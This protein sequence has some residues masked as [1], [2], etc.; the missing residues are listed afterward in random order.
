[1]KSTLQDVLTLEPLGAD[2]F[3]AIHHKENFQSSLFGGQVLAQS[4]MAA[5]LT[6]DGSRPHSM[7]AYF[8]RAG[9]SQAPVDYTVVRNRDGRSFSHRTVNAEQNG[10]LI[11]TAMVSFHGEDQGFE[12]AD[13]W[14]QEPARPELAKVQ[15]SPELAPNQPELE[16]DAFAFYP[17]TKGMLSTSSEKE[18][19]TLFWMR[20]VEPL[21]DTPLMQACALAYASDFGLLATSL[22]AHP[23]SLFSGEVMGA[24]IDHALWF[25]RHDFSLNDW[26][27]YEID[28]PWAGNARGFSRG[29]IFNEQGQLLASCSQEGLIRPKT[30]P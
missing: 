21:L 6:V 30:T 22:T 26:L 8:L 1:M 20:C 19:A 18:A 10:K 16:V 23:A 5:G 28:S 24:S 13:S 12:H 17:L 15:A 27:F 9:S 2:V 25:H 4:L 11:F 7:H 14:H 3:R 29:K